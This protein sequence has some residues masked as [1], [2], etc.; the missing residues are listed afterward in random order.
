M[1][2]VSVLG[3]YVSVACPVGAFVSVAV[4][5]GPVAG[6]GVG[7]VGVTVGVPGPTVG[8]TLPVGVTDPAGVGVRVGT[9]GPPIMMA[10]QPLVRTAIA[11]TNA[12]IARNRRLMVSPP[13]AFCRQTL[14]S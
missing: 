5:F 7:P 13:R 10:V 2:K 12:R 9:V 6:V 11:P 1:L 4:P 14:S 8:V 3:S